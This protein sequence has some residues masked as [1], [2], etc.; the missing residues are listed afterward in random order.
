MR[1]LTA[2]TRARFRAAPS[3][4]VAALLAA[5][6]AV[7][8]VAGGSAAAPAVPRCAAAHLGV[9]AGP[10]T[11]GAGH[12]L[13]EFAFVNRGSGRCSLFGYPHVW[14]LDAAGH[15]IA[16]T[17]RNAAPGADGIAEKVV[18]LAGG[19]RAYFGVYYADQTGFGNLMCPAAARLRFHPPQ[20]TAALV[21]SGKGAHIAPYG[22]S[23]PHLHCGMVEVTPVTAKRFQ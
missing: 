8:A 10:V 21:L 12:L 13:S 6:I 15:P 9:W 2:A 5:M 1:A 22:G 17:D 7:G 3:T 20:Q 14:M 19:R 11:G 18:L 16:T 4:A 23:I